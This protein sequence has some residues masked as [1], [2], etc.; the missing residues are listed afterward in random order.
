[1]SR[2]LYYLVIKPLSLLPFWIL[3]SVSDFMFFILYYLVGYRKSVVKRNL[4][5]SFPEKKPKEIE[6]IQKKFFKHLC[7][8]VVEDIRLFSMPREEVKSRFKIINPEILEDYYNQ[9]RSVILVGG[10]YNNYE[11]AGIS[12]DMYSSHQ[13]IGIYSPLSDKFFDKIFAQSRSR[14]G[15]EIIPKGLVPRSF[16]LNKSKLTMTIFGA[17]QSPT[18]S[19]QVHWTNFLNQ[20]TAVH[21]GTELFAVK[22]NYP[23]VFIKINKVNRGYYEGV[24]EVICDNPASSKKGEITELHTKEL[25]RII[26]DKP[27]YWLWSHKRWK[28]TKTV[29]ER[30]VEIEEN[31]AK[32]A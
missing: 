9:K 3:Y 16:V 18:F 24:L 4:I 11:L 32:A 1:M 6:V 7:D 28:R 30:R 20:E 25:E 5:N 29:E 21:V 31:A 12:F 2:L 17:D 13:A 23:V 14:H 10:H 15:V 26:N 8:L 27:Q 22:Y 19:K